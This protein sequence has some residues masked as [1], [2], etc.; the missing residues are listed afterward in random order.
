MSAGRI[1]IVEDDA[2]SATLLKAILSP[3]GDCAIAE[4]G[5]KAMEA[6]NSAQGSGQPFGLVC[7]DIMLPGKDGQEVLKEI[8]EAEAKADIPAPDGV[9]IIMIT[10]LKDKENVMNA[11]RSQCEAYIVKPIRKKE[12]IAQLA[13]LGLA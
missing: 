13:S 9:P 3:Y 5:M 1:L 12:V 4:D 10:A 7:L 6:W 2:V 8:R 11:F